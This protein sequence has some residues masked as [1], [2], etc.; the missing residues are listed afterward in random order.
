[1]R[2][3]VTAEEA[4]VA[5]AQESLERFLIAQVSLKAA[6]E[7]MAEARTRLWAVCKVGNELLA[8]D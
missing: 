2:D 6:K 1:M 4:S 7:E 8:S 5:R 3:Y